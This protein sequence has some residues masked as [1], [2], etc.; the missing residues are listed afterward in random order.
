MELERRLYRLPAS[1]SHYCSKATA[2][3][4]C[5]ARSPDLIIDLTGTNPGPVSAPTLK[6]LFDL[7]ARDAAAA[8][9][10]LARRAPQIDLMLI[11]PGDA[12]RCIASATP[13]LENRKLFTPGVRA[14]TASLA[15]LLENAV[16]RIASGRPLAFADPTA[17]QGAPPGSPAMFALSALGAKIANR[18]TRFAVHREHFRV[19]WRRTNAGETMTDTLSWPEQSYNYLPDDGKR[20]FADPFVFSHQGSAF[21]FCEEF[22]YAAGKG[23]LTA[24]ELLEDGTAGPPLPVMEQPW[25]LSYPQVF[26]RDGEI[27][28]IP[29]TCAANRIELYRA[30][31][32]PD[33]WTREAI[34][35]EDTPASDA[36][37]IEH[38]GRLWLFATVARDG[39][40]SWDALCLYHA[41]RLTGPWTAHIANPVLIDASC[42]R[43]AGAM[44]TRNGALWRPAQDC[45]EGY[46]GGIALCAVERLDEHEFRQSVRARVKPPRTLGAHG[47]HTLNVAGGIETIDIVGA[48]ARW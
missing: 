6:P 44:F 45:S 12:P 11:E 40:S 17:P 46:G 3:R 42:A 15:S 13:A 16:D 32:F 1:A 7:R 35:V 4:N 30:T 31:R 19:G 29:E 18:L 27:W 38:G 5:L 26:A 24:F 10:L 23:V 33:R 9:A 25:H 36:T 39:L 37:L 34:L 43:P 20:Y 21:L 48:R 28:M 41:D 14:V 47:A 8:D 22:P 2:P